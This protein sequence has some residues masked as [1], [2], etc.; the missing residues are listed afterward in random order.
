[1]LRATVVG[2]TIAVALRGAWGMISI[3]NPATVLATEEDVEAMEWIREH[4]PTDAVFLINVRPW[5]LGIYVGSDGGY[6]IPCM[7][8]RRA[9]LPALSYAHGG[10][11]YV[12]AVGEHARLVHEVRDAEEP[13]LRAL[14]AE[15]A[16]THVYIGAKGGTL[17]P[18]MF[19]RSSLYRPVY[20]SGQ[21]WIFEVLHK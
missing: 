19:V 13:R 4:A 6:W 12:G 11:E 3:V 14:L 20:C 21:V 1:M 10:P 15:E 16:V 9:I 5:Q 2:V 18:Q 17:T 8:G 7:T